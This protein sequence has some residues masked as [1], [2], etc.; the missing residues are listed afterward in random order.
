MGKEEAEYPDVSEVD[1]SQ[2]PNLKT[3]MEKG[4][5]VVAW[6]AK[7]GMDTKGARE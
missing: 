6:L 1:W 2:F 5:D 7:Q 4:G 3:L